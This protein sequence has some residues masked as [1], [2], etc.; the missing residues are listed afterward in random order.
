MHG[1]R[2]ACFVLLAV[3]FGVAG[4]TAQSPP[5]RFFVQV[6]R[7]T[8]DLTPPSPA[9]KPI[10]PKLSKCLCSV[11]RWKSYW[12]MDRQ[13]V[14]IDS[15]RT[16]HVHLSDGRDLELGLVA[17]GQV[18]LRLLKN[19]AVARK[20]RFSS[21]THGLEIMGG[22]QSDDNSWFVVVRRD[23]PLEPLTAP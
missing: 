23:Q 15:A 12:E 22:A 7:G 17:K 19:G 9:A 1:I 16:G 3:L 21:Q 6:V 8:D 20:C 10:G 13:V 18:E 4:A 5:T 2:V 11:F 14:K